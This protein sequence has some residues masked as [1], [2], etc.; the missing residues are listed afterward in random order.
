MNKYQHCLI[1]KV[2]KKSKKP[3][4]PIENLSKASFILPDNGY[5]IN[6]LFPWGFLNE[7]HITWKS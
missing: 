2:K 7:H 3:V 6:M 4:K 5:G 1:H